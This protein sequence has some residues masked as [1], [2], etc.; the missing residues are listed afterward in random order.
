MKKTISLLLS[1]MLLTSS[2]TWSTPPKNTRGKTPKKIEGSCLSGN[3]AN[4]E[5][6]WRYNDGR[7]YEGNFIAG[8]PSGLGTIFMPSGSTYEGK[9]KYG[10]YDGG[11]YVLFDDGSDAECERGNCINGRG[12][13]SGTRTN[14]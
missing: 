8:K 10:Q 3:C 6:V 1:S 13:T 7:R 4:G 9:F 14:N 5:G 11:G 12:I 2:C